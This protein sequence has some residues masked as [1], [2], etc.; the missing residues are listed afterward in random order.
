[1]RFVEDLKNINKS[2][3]TDNVQIN[4]DGDGIIKII[5]KILINFKNSWKNLLF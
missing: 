5:S 1:M 3:V 2:M 4:K